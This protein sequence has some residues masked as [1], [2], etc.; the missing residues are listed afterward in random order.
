MSEEHNS[1]DI[2]QIIAENFGANATYVE[3]LLSRFRS[4]RSLVDEASPIRYSAFAGLIS[5]F[6]MLFSPAQGP[7]LL[8]AG[9]R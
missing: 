8:G 6:V 3:G 4:N 2:S 5:T 9:Q 1:A 7:G